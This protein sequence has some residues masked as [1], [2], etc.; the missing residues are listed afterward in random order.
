ML[1]K[2]G[3][4]RR[5]ADLLRVQNDLGELIR[6]GEAGDDFVGHVGTQVDREREREVRRP[7]NVSELLGALEL[8]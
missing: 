6:L 8:G 4:V 1:E 5:V 2:G 7:D 3:V